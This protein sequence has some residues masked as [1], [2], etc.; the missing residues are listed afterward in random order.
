[1][2]IAVLAERS[3]TGGLEWHRWSSTLR[4]LTTDEAAVT[5]ARRIVDGVLDT[6][7]QAAS[8]IRPDSELL[9]LPVGRPVRVSCTLAQIFAAAL[10]ATELT[11]GAGGHPCESDIEL[12]PSEHIVTVPAGVHLDLAGIARA[13][14][15]DRCV[16]DVADLL[17][18]GVLVAVGGAVATAPPGGSWPGWD[19]EVGTAEPWPAGSV[20][21]PSGL[22]VGTVT[23][24]EPGWR[25]AG[26]RQQPAGLPPAV[27]RPG[28]Y[29]R[30]ASVV[31]PDCVTAHAWAAAALGNGGPAMRRLRGMGL[32][33]RLVTA[34]GVV[35]TVGAW[36]DRHELGGAA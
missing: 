17:G 23:D 5:E 22:A 32:P 12:D 26:P 14:A 9:S 20:H 4:L 1:M 33:A 2:T 15:A 31:A 3:T 19:I 28:A 16:A 8:R 29:W 30:S 6:V 24:A 11:G 27:R 21:L 10:A 25:E 7:E 18:V 13:W 34:A 35:R 36:P